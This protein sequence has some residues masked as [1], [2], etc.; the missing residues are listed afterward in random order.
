MRAVMTAR[1]G[2]GRDRSRCSE[3]VAA[4]FG[5]QFHQ[6]SVKQPVRP[7]VVEFVKIIAGWLDTC[8]INCRDAQED[9][10][11]KSRLKP[12]TGTEIANVRSTYGR[13]DHTPHPPPDNIIGRH[14]RM[15]SISHR[16]RRSASPLCPFHLAPSALAVRMKSFV[17][18]CYQRCVV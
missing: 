5:L 15:S 11:P 9:A 2:R 4:E 10:N 1:G 17:R 8:N 7:G 16:P 6:R 18:P 12:R 14:A 3:L 13:N